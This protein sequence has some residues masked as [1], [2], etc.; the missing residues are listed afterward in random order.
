MEWYRRLNSNGVCRCVDMRM[1]CTHQHLKGRHQ[2][3]RD[4]SDHLQ[5]RLFVNF[6]SFFL[7]FSKKDLSFR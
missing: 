3:I 2:K 4:T 1:M 5:I 6:L 7:L